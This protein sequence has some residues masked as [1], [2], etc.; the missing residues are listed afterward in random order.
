MSKLLTDH[1]KI[2]EWVSAHAGNPAMTSVP[3]G[4]GGEDLV[5]KFT[6]GQRIFSTDQ[7]EAR[8]QLG[9][10]EQVTWAEWFEQFEKHGLALRIPDVFDGNPAG[11]YSIE[12]RPA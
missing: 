6:F 11:V 10:V 8:D 4:H 5:L 3:N 12:P 1:D 9:G 7:D 2:R